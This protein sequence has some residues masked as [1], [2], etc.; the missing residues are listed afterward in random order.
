MRDVDIVG[1]HG[2]DGTPFEVKIADLGFARK[3]EDD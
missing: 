2:N 1:K 3:L